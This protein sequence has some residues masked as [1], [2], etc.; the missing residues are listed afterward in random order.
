MIGRASTSKR[1]QQQQQ[2]QQPASAATGNQ[3]P[4]DRFCIRTD[5]RGPGRA[6]FNNN[7]LVELGAGRRAVVYCR[8][9]PLIV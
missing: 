2:Q 1:L 4:D 6:Q 3:W 5:G 8:R 9:M 7:S